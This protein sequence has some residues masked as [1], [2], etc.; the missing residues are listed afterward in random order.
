MQASYEQV[1]EAVKHFSDEEIHKLGEFVREKELQNN[2]KS[3]K[4][5]K[6]EEEIRKFNLAMKWIDEHRQEY[7]GKWICLDGDNLISF[8]N[9]GDEVYNQAK[10]SGIEIPFMELVKEEETAYLGGWEACR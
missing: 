1:I 2:E 4:S 7:L 5:A 10:R 3:K 8:G 6:V 9:D